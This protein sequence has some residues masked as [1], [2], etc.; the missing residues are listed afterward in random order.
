MP[1]FVSFSGG[2]LKTWFSKHDGQKT[3]AKAATQEYPG[4]SPHSCQVNVLFILL[5]DVT[6]AE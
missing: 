5:S 2:V 1:I 4:A 3:A 6:K